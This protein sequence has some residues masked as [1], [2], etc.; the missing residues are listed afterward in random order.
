MRFDDL[1]R[2]SNIYPEPDI[3]R[4]DYLV[5]YI[6]QVFGTKITRI[7]DYTNETLHAYH[8]YSNISP[9]NADESYIL[10]LNGPYH[11]ILLDGVTYQYIK[12]ITGIFSSSGVSPLLIWHPYDPKI[13]IYNYGNELRSLN[14]ETDQ[15]ITLHTFSDYLNIFISH[16]STR[17]SIDG[18]ILIAA[19]NT[20]SVNALID[21]IS[22]DIINDV[23]STYPV[24]TQVADRTFTISISGRYA[25][26]MYP[27]YSSIEGIG[28]AIYSVNPQTMQLTYLGNGMTPSDHG[29]IVLLENGEDAFCTLNSGS[30]DQVLLNF[31]DLSVTNIYHFTWWGHPH[32]GSGFAVN[33]RGWIIDEIS[34]GP[35]EAPNGITNPLEDEIIAIK[36]DGSGEVRRIAHHHSTSY[37]PINSTYWSQPRA[38]VNKDATKIIFDSNWR[39]QIVTDDNVDSYIIELDPD[40]GCTN[41]LVSFNIT[42]IPL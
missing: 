32:H 26:I 11:W 15:I 4:P 5:P 18:K 14:V 38:V 37:Y 27:G 31:S 36:L 42:S 24:I 19:G 20:S 3:P 40:N 12:T 39:G 7:S 35:T 25:M 8:F 28:T 33:R 23:V 17:C 29:D 22:Y 13:V 41:P 6:D 2:D 30:N 9:W 34:G 16:H 1:I 10:L 21:F